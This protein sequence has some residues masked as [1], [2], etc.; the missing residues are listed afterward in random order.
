MQIRFVALIF[1]CLFAGLFALT[2]DTPSQAATTLP[3][4]MNFQGR[5]ANST[6]S[7]LANGTYNI[8]FKLWNLATGGAQQWSEDRLISAG[9]GVVVTNGQFSVQLGSVTTLPASVFTSNSLYFE[10]ELPTPA[11]ATT[12]SPVWTEGAMTP[13][14]QLATSAYA[15]NAET[16]DGID[17]DAFAKIGSTNAFTAAN[18]VD[19]SS[20]NAFQ[21]KNGSTNLFNVSTS[22]SIVTLGASDTTGAVLVLDVKTDPGDPGGGSATPGAMYYNSNSGKFRCYQ[23]SAW[24]D[25]ITAVS[26]T[27][28]QD[29][30]NN[31]ASGVADITTSSSAK[32]FLFKAGNTFDSATLF[33][34][35]DAAGADLFVVDSTN[36]RVY[37]G[38][39]TADAIGSVLVLDTKNTTGD[40]TGVAGAIYYNSFLAK[41]RC[42]E[43][44]VWQSC[45]AS[46]Q[47]SAS[48]AT[49]AMSAG[50][51]TYLAGSA[52]NLPAGGMQGPTGTN[53]DGTLITWRI[54]MSKT[55]AGTAASTFTMRFGTAG[56]TADTSR[57]TFA[58]GTAT[59]A[60]DGAVVTITAYA[61]AGGTATVLN[62]AGTLT[63]Q[64]PATGFANTAI[65]QAYS[66]SASFN[67]TTASTKAGL[68]LS[69]GSASVITVQKVEVTAINL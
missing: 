62:C 4:K 48:T 43:A 2:T 37:V 60:V 57:C 58:T 5:I 10:V 17:S 13:R 53:Q 25:C 50:V 66:T 54:T 23:V 30:Y 33:G 51:D 1:A 63:H 55:N 18:S 6:G 31:D 46:P 47:A 67:S 32:T 14:N 44:G 61:T 59:A 29:A 69:T 12:G 64:L 8:R 42:Y 39:P 49:Q 56:T 16:L 9:N 24:T 36:D 65:V 28:L 19:V 26:T 34:I 40:P 7:I 3:T 21:V 15:Y 20:A 22:G 45:S 38:D 41:F 68:S 11:S 27:T 35:Q 52:I